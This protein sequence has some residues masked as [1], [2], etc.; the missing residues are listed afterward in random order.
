VLIRALTVV[1]VVAVLAGG[2]TVWLL[3]RERPRQ[4]RSAAG[5]AR[6]LQRMAGA[7][8]VVALASLV[9]LRPW[10]W[11]LALGMAA[12]A[13]LVAVVGLLRRLARRDAPDTWG[14][15]LVALASVVLGSGLIALGGTAAVLDVTALWGGDPR[16]IPHARQVLAHPVLYQVFWGAAWAATP[17]PPALT[18]AVAFQRVLPTSSWAVAVADAG[19]GVD[20]FS[21]GGCWIDPRTP[22]VPVRATTTSSGP[23]PAE[24]RAV[25]AGR[26]RLLPCPGSAPRPVP[27]LLPGDAVVAL[28]LSPGAP[29]G[30]GGV[31]AHGSTPWTGHPAGLVVTGLSDGFASWG[32]AGCAR[33][34]AC[35]ALPAFAT[36]TYALSHEVVESVT[37]PFGQG[38]FADPPLQWSAAYLFHHGPTSLLG[39]APPFQ[40]EVADLCQPGQPDATEERLPEP[41]TS[42][43]FAVAAF[44]RPG[45][46]CVF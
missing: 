10:Y 25:F 6:V 19:F 21:S 3:V 31:S 15:V 42:D 46:G 44:Y 29:Y 18:E 27:A 16:P 39:P 36:P 28:W 4:A 17:P 8:V 14:A 12:V 38:W 26:R 24:L 40:G 7:S 45:L 2:G 33:A 23:F 13:A 37:N 43:G 32:E 20:S 5:R 35:R 41:T 11:A 34:A 30:L 1:A 22:G 9:F